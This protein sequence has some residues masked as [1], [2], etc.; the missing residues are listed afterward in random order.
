MKK[1]FWIIVCVFL[2]KDIQAFTTIHGA[3]GL[4]TV[5]T[6]EALQYKQYNM[7]YDYIISDHAKDDEWFFKAN[8]G[9]FKSCEI[10][11]VAGK[12]PTEGVF[13]NIKYYLMADAEKF[14]LSIAIGCEDLFSKSATGL[15]M[16][17]S[18]KFSPDLQVHLGFKG[19][20]QTDEMVT[21][22][23]GGADYWLNNTWAIL[24]DFSGQR[25]RYSVNL[26]TRYALNEDVILSVSVLD[27]GSAL[28]TSPQYAMGLSFVKFL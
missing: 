3:S 26:G 13:V 25:K 27:I 2:A 11:I 28:H 15:Y 18:K 19:V 14:P 17:A 10:G 6:A 12:V 5:P 8:L 21:Y 22:V 16:V 1:I 24:A 4:I 7:G 23:M 9:T 20:F